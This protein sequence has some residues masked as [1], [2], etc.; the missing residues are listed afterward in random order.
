MRKM[1]AEGFLTYAKEEIEKAKEEGGSDRIKALS[2]TVDAVAKAKTDGAETVI[3]KSFDGSEEIEVQVAARMN[4]GK[5]TL[6][7]SH[8]EASATGQGIAENIDELAKQAKT[9][10]G[11]DDASD[12]AKKGDDDGNA[13]ATDDQKNVPAE[14]D[15]EWPDD[16]AAP[17][18]AESA[19]GNDPK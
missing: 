17:E 5:P 9:L 14:H 18:G 16:M 4:D 19:W 11:D 7:Q 3:V 10:K 15:D 13:A 12:D 6:T 2:E 8:D 1:N